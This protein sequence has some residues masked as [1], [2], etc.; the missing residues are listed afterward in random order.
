MARA[1]GWSALS[2][3]WR[4]NRAHN[5]TINNML[6]GIFDTMRNASTSRGGQPAGRLRRVLAGTGGG[7]S[8]RRFGRP[9]ELG[10]YFAFL[11]SEHAGFITGQN[12]L[13]DGGKLSRDIL[14]RR[15]IS[16][17]NSHDARCSIVCLSAAAG[18]WR[19]SPCRSRGKLPLAHGDRGRS[20]SAG[21]IRSMGLLA[22][23]CRSSTRRPD[24]TS[25]SR[26][27]PA[28]H[29]VSSE[30]MPSRRQ[31]RT[32]TPFWSLPRCTSSIRSCTRACPTTW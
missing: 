11:C 12:L 31:L 7:E 23:W 30:R 28:A 25:S 2:R 13:V 22:S 6:P 4:A 3:G 17:A 14:T 16:D 8:A 26:T 15:G 21:R 29:P 24:S 32:A 27:A 18:R 20:V 1:R 10:A 9:S 5:V 19:S